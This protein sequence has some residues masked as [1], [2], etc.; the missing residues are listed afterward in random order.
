M[1]RRVQI[2]GVPVLFLGLTVANGCGGSNAATTAPSSISSQASSSV[3]LS[4]E[5]AALRFEPMPDPSCLPGPARGTRLVLVIVGDAATS[6]RGIRFGFVPDGGTTIFPAVVPIPG[7][8]PL[9][10]PAN[11]IPPQQS[12]PTPGVAP[13]PTSMPIPLPQPQRLPFFA[14]FGCGPFGDGVL[15]V[16]ADFFDRLGVPGTSELRA[17]VTH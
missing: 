12:L 2:V 10:V 14:S 11:A 4:A 7:P 17:R 5:P 8:S 6:L 1:V 3:G 15:V 13:L 9:S 16:T